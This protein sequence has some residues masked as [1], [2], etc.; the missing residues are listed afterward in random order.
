[1]TATNWLCRWV[2]IVVVSASVRLWAAERRTMS[3]AVT[4]VTSRCPVCADTLDVR[5][6]AIALIELLAVIALGWTLPGMS[7]AMDREPALSLQYSRILVIEH[8]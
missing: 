6:R 8:R 2:A 5:K 7:G 3:S 4:P 1:M